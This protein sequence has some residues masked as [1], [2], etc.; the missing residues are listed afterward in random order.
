[1]SYLL[2]IVFNVTITMLHN[3]YYIMLCRWA[4]FLPMCL[5]PITI[6]NVNYGSN[7]LPGTPGAL[8]D[9]SNSKIGVPC[10]H[11]KE[12]V[13]MRQMDL[14]QRAQ[15]EASCSHVFFLT[16]TYNEESLP[17]LTTS[18]GYTFKYADWN[19]LQDT[20]KRIRN[21]NAFTRPFKY[22][23]VSERGSKYGRPHFHALLFLQ[24]YPSDDLHTYMNLEGI[25]FR[26]FLKY[27]AKNVG[28][29]KNPIYRP[30]LTY[31]RVVIKGKVH[32]TYDLHA[33]IP[34]LESSGISDVTFYITKYML[35]DAE[36]DD[37]R[38]KALKLNL[39][40]DEFN[41]VWKTIKSKVITSK[42][43]GYGFTHSDYLH[44]VDKLRK[45]VDNSDEFPNYTNVDNGFQLPL[46]KYYKSN[47]FIYNFNDALNY[48]YRSH[49][50]S[51][52]T[53]YDTKD[54]SMTSLVVAEQKFCKSIS[55][56]EDSEYDVVINSLLTDESMKFDSLDDLPLSSAKE[57]LK[58]VPFNTE[59]DF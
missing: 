32:S 38:R 28:S 33:I 3:L 5:S 19:D 44:I 47:P 57:G 7:P 37:K 41:F 40:P 18:S 35:K 8:K 21:N 20:F 52:D 34:T 36:K 59:F 24:K 6:P 30:L 17:K 22:L 23:A 27:Y 15:M 43:F 25:C 54:R 13:A 46:S 12:C 26:E 31:K 2:N 1:M 14:V 4:F 42:F 53:P 16:C 58:N 55:A 49:R 51:V 39:E 29:R 9:C 48:Y 11:C 10:R 50:D 45:D 56:I